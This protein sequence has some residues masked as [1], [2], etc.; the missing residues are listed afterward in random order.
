MFD[1]D[2]SGALS[3]LKIEKA[4]HAGYRD[5]QKGDLRKS[6]LEGDR[7]QYDDQEDKEDEHK[8]S[9]ASSTAAYANTTYRITQSY[10]HHFCIEAYATTYIYYQV[11]LW[12]VRL[13]ILL[14][15][16]PGAST[17]E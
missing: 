17:P 13:P 15:F 8:S 12:S 5:G 11:S 2:S 16:L 9:P 3:Y 14:R 1:P 7:G 4:H 10:H 6:G